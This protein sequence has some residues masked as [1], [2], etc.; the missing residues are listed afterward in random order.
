[1]RVLVTGGAGFIGSNFIRIA[2][3][4]HADW[5]I[6]NFD[7]LT[8]AGNLKSLE[9]ISR[10]PRYGFIKGDIAERA[11]L[12]KAFESGIDLVV[13]FAA[14]THVDKSLYEAS[15]FLRTNAVGV[16]VLLETALEHSVERLI[17]IST[18]EVYGSITDGQYASE[19]SPLRPSSPYSASKA[20]ADLLCGAFFKTHGLPVIITR[21][22]NNYGPY[23]FPEKIIPYFITEAMAGRQMP[24]YGLGV[25]IRNWLHVED[26]CRAILTLIDRGV[27]GDIYNIGGANYL[28]NLSLTRKLLLILGLSESRIKYV[29]DRPGH[30]LRYAIDCSRIESLGWK[31]QIDFDEGLRRTVRWYI[32]NEAWWCEIL[33]G[34]HRKF[35]ERHYKN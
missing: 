8:Y 27:P 33:S 13:N 11:D 35:Q 3:K 20:A 22:S 28:D 29:E 1:M 18:D 7:L 19:Q 21:S 15:L 5:E 32:E 30:D 16:G 10:D 6:V 9:D 34:E 23:Q 26:N 2:L 4:S 12:E 25:N 17:H 31:P 14:E 24:L